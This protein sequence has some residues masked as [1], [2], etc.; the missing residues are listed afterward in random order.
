M[1]RDV[2]ERIGALYRAGRAAGFGILERDVEE[3]ARGQRVSRVEAGLAVEAIAAK[4]LAHLSKT[5][6]ADPILED[7]VDHAGDRIRAVLGGRPVAQY[8]DPLQAEGRDLPEIRALGKSARDERRAV[9]PFTVDE[10]QR[11]VGR[12]TAQAGRS[13]KRGAF[14][15]GQPL[16]V[17]RRHRLHEFVG[18]FGR[19]RCLQRLRADD[20][21][22]HHG[23]DH[24][25]VEPTRTGDGQGIEFQ[26]FGTGT[27][28]GGDRS[29]ARQQ[30]GGSHE[31]DL[32]TECLQHWWMNC[33]GGRE[34]DANTPP[35]S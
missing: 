4:I 20:V 34:V 25:A 3:S 15:D 27:G 35:A 11:L 13:H 26:R 12:E 14:A 28:L 7:Q 18:E 9:L 5:L 10:N 21:D 6:V 2:G 19:D 33:D 31:G 22:G 8:L 32:G 16:H 23:F 29:Q 17:E 1:G 24:G 30:N